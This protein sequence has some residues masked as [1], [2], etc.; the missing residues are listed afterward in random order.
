MLVVGLASLMVGGESVPAGLACGCS[1]ARPPRGGYSMVGGWGGRVAELGEA[2][3]GV[4]MSRVLVLR[5]GEGDLNARLEA[6][7]KSAPVMLFMKGS[8]DEPKCGFSRTIISLL[9]EAKVPLTT[10]DILE[11][12]EVRQGLKAYSN[13]P[14]YPQLY[15][16]GKLIGG[17]DVVKELA[18]AGELLSEL[19]VAPEPEDKAGVLTAKIGK[20]LVANRVEVQ[21]LS[22]G[23]GLKY[24][25]V[26]VSEKFEGMREN[27]LP[28]CIHSPSPQSEA[29][30]FHA[31]PVPRSSPHP[32]IRSPAAN[33]CVRV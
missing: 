1:G 29:A 33:H 9:H 7:I 11:D 20:A 28:H 12:E 30:I 4:E 19:G 32:K 24:S 22:D 26:V 17:L 18:E 8:P 3:D 13:W 14:T 10:F 5:G 6:L 25:V 27:P 2:E 21:D 16:N 23:C 31:S 15:A